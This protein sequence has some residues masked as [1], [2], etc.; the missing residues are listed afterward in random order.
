M[1]IRKIC[2]TILSDYIPSLDSST[3]SNDANIFS[4]PCYG[5]KEGNGL[6]DVSHPIN[7]NNKICNYPK[8]PGQNCVGDCANLFE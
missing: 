6:T 7:T 8:L 5:Q 1:F 2:V 3:H 4:L